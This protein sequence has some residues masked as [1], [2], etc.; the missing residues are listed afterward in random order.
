VFAVRL[1]SDIWVSAYLRR[2][3]SDGVAAVL[4]RR[5]SS[6]AGAILVKIYRLDGDVALYGPAPQSVA[7]PMDVDRMFVRLNRSEWIP[8][9]DAEKRLDRE[10]AFD[11]DIWIIDLE[12]RA[13]A[14]RLDLTT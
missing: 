12:D 6:E 5:G 3:A 2:C 7:L 13:G 9:A 11:P 14:P 4:R 8:A 1:R 10:I